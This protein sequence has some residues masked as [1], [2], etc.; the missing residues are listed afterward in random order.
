[1]LKISTGRMA[2]TVWKPTTVALRV[3]KSIRQHELQFNQ[4]FAFPIRVDNYYHFIRSAM[5]VGFHTVLATSP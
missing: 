4:A 3:E 1:M 5:V 2:S